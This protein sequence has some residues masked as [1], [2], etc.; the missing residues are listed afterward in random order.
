MVS[1]N[2]QEKKQMKKYFSFIIYNYCFFSINM[3]EKLIDFPDINFNTIHYLLINFI[4]NIYILCLTNN[5]QL[6][7][8][9]VII[10]EGCMIIFDY[11]TIS[12]EECLNTTTY[13]IKY[14]DAI[15]F[16]YQ[17][18]LSKINITA[19]EQGTIINNIK[20]MNTNKNLGL[21]ID[22]IT[23]I[24]NIFYC[25]FKLQFTIA[26]DTAIFLK[27]IDLT[28]YQSAI[29]ELKANAILYVTTERVICKKIDKLHKQISALLFYNVDII[30]HFIINLIPDIL[31]CI[32]SSDFAQS[33]YNIYF[34]YLTE[35]YSKLEVN[36]QVPNPKLPLTNTEQ[37]T[38]YNA[39]IIIILLVQQ[40]HYNNIS[41]S[42]LPYTVLIDKYYSVLQNIN[43]DKD[44]EKIFKVHRNQLTI[45]HLFITDNYKQL[46]L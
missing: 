39:F 45:E 10:D 41:V 7:K 24:K 2:I 1:K 22:G 42:Q 23:L 13:K 33:I 28:H 34:G 37:N 6:D 20:P 27:Y 12:R 35:Y 5:I 21:V 9:K 36:N 18:M 26:T 38:D 29:S 14:N 8:V 17:K 3:I 11:L 46:F 25:L 4:T 19:K 15:H 44:C 40:H 32:K 16:A 31:S 43:Y 30:E